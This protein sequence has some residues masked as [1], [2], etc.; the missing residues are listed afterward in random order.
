[1]ND[2]GEEIL[3]ISKNIALEGFTLPKI[4]WVMENEPE[5][6]EKARHI[7]LPKDYL[8]LYL[9]GN[10]HMDLSD[11]A[12]TLLLDVEKKEWSR[13][14]ADKFAINYDYL[15][16][17]VDSIGY[18]GDIRDE[19]RDELGIKSR[20]KVYAGAADNAASAVGAGIIDNK[21]FMYIELLLADSI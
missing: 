12:G 17:L 18:T 9:T 10:Y 8:R 5:I 11:A 1:M 6:W 20:V 7:Q 13:E 14:I 15:P 21:S 16:E 4:L 2:F 3:S 19:V